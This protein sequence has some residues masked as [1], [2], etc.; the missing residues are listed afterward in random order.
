MS[1][2]QDQETFLVPLEEKR[3]RNPEAFDFGDIEEPQRAKREAP[4]GLS[5]MLGGYSEE[6]EVAGRLFLVRPPKLREQRELVRVKR[7]LDSIPFDA[8]DAEER[9]LDALIGLAKCVLHVAEESGS[10]P[11]KAEE[12]E[13]A[14]DAQE[15]QEIIARATGWKAQEGKQGDPPAL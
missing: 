9:Y 2:I 14:F 15:V 11:A 8:P 10:R 7:E 3:R 4:V 6:I 1:I 12:I 13:A 5:A